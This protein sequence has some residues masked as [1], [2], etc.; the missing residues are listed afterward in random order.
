MSVVPVF[1]GRVLTG[2]LL[3]LDRPKDYARYVRSFAGQY[4][5]VTIRKQRSQRSTDQNRWWRGVAVPLIAEAMGHDRHE[6]D[7]VHYALVA[8]CFG[9]TV[10]VKTGLEIPNV[11]SSHLST[12]EFSEL[13]EWAVR[14][15]AQYLNVVV[16]LP[17]EVER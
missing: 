1:K 12:A 15:A 7:Q 2:G 13:M 8:K 10:D 6:Y 9:S 14:F 11:R 16:P 5:E 4:V 3:A 17:G